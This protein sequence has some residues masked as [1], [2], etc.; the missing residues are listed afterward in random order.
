[1]N[2]VILAFAVGFAGGFG[3]H[4]WHTKVLNAAVEKLRR[5]K[6]VEIKQLRGEKNQLRMQNDNTRHLSDCA[7]AFRKG[8]EIGRYGPATQAE[9]FAKSFENRRGNTTFVVTGNG[10]GKQSA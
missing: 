8:K 2:G 1:M 10:G 6:D 3:M 5:E 4:V 7:D 9:K